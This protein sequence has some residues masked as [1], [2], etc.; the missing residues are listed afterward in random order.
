M[1]KPEEIRQLHNE[2]AETLDEELENAYG[3]RMAFFLLVCPFNS[4]GR[5]NYVSNAQRNDAQRMMSELILRWQSE[6]MGPTEDLEGLKGTS[7]D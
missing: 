5:I 6:D 3:E 1:K 2:I 7:V 4:K